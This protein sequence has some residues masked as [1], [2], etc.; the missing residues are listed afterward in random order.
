MFN[1]ILYIYIPGK[2]SSHTVCSG[3]VVRSA[4]IRTQAGGNGNIAVQSA[5]IVSFRNRAQTECRG[6][7]VCKAGEIKRADRLRSDIEANLCDTRFASSSFV[8]HLL[9]QN[10]RRMLSKPVLRASRSLSICC[11]KNL[12]LCFRGQLCQQLIRLSCCIKT[13]R[14][15]FRSQF[16]QRL[17]YLSCRTKR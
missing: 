11:S 3:L 13:L 2:A 17:I 16:C 7:A 8:E 15:C 10:F 6:S 5:V 14:L 12:G 4:A 9:R 1:C